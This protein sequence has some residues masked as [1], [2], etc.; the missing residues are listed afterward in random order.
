M[1]ERRKLHT[2]TQVP[3]L[4]KGIG[5]VYLLNK[6][7]SRKD[8]HNYNTRRKNDFETSNAKKDL[9]KNKF[10]NKSLIDY[11]NILA[12]DTGRKLKSTG[13]NEKLFNVTDS[14]ITFKKK[15]RNYLLQTRT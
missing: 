13:E 6:L 12:L 5:P 8:I 15:L 14:I 9:N 1:E 2:L 3:K 7:K 4:K 10:F 11:N